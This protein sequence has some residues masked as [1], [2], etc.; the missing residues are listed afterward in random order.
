MEDLEKHPNSIEHMSLG[1]SIFLQL[2]RWA[3][4]PI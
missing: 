4:I 3:A 1:W 2:N